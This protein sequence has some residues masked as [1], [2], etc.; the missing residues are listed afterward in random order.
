MV[1]FSRA[2][3]SDPPF[4]KTLFG[5]TKFATMW[6]IIRLYV[7][8]SWIQAGLHKFEDPKWM[9]TGEALKGYWA[10][11]VAIPET[12]R[13]AISFDWYRGFL[14]MLLDGSHYTWF[15]KLVTFGELLVGIALIIGAFTGI[16]AFF[17]GLMNWNFMMAGS[18]STNPFLFLLA[19]FLVL[20][21]KTAGWLGADQWLLPKLGTPWQPTR[22]N[23]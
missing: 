10:K 21:W 4:A 13:P 5:D 1:D 20:A 8:W 15:A 23:L 19:V 22:K 11:A 12:G 3:I 18:A 14:Q 6:L 7:G 16:A 9:A 17:G 2:E